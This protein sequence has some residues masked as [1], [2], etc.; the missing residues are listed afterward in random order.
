MPKSASL[1]STWREIASRDSSD[2]GL[3]FFFGSSSRASGGS[4]PGL[5]DG[6]NRGTWRS[7]STRALVWTFAIT[8]SMRGGL[9]RDLRSR[10]TSILAPRSCLTRLASQRSR[11]CTPRR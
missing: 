7:R 3:R 11:A 6:S 2:T 4:V 8:G 5:G 9:R 10:S 1:S